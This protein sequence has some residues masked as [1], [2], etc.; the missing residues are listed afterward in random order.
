MSAI[1][2]LLVDDHDLFRRGLME[3]LSE[4]S[5]MEVIGEAR[6][7]LEAIDRVEELSPD[8]VFMDLN[9]PGQSGIETT[10]YLTQKWPDMKVLV[11]TVSE[12]AADLYNA[13]KVGD[14]KRAR[15]LGGRPRVDKTHF[16]TRNG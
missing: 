14:E 10:A 13:L 4:E 16:V 5:D 9:M 1:R 6:N 7:G 3:V 15:P 12:E 11:L 2:V 8:V